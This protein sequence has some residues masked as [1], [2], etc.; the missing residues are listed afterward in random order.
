MGKQFDEK[1][2]KK[3]EFRPKMGRP[4]RYEI[5]VDDEKWRD[6]HRTIFG[7]NPSLPSVSSQ[8]E[9]IAAFDVYEYKRV[10]G[11]AL[12]RLSAQSLHSEQLAKQ[13]L[14]RLVQLRTIE[15]VVQELREILILDDEAWLR[16]VM[17]NQQNRCSLKATLSKLRA[18]GLSNESIQ[19]I[20]EEWSDPEAEDKAIQNL[21]KTRYRTKN[22]R[23]YSVRQKV[24]ASLMR[25]GYSFEQVKTA[26]S[27]F[28][29]SSTVEDL[30]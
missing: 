18:K 21:L 22:L 6:V 5:F 16:G 9:L 25:K 27:L 19:R 17:R 24:I 11:Y 3:I 7:R 4:D 30:F 2:E 29:Q 8:E 10:K 13:L 20:K 15:C 28:I 23:E 14:D 26:L 1:A 12:W